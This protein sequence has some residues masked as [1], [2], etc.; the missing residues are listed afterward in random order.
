MTVASLAVTVP[1]REG[2]ETVD[3]TQWLNVTAFGRL[4][5]DLAQ[6]G[7]GEMV[8]VIGRAQLRRYQAQDGGAREEIGIVADSLVSARTSRPSS[9]KRTASSG[10][11]TS[12]LSLSPSSTM[13]SRFRDDRAW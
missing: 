7:K 8:A 12:S 5:D 2:G 13:I 4:A 11:S 10:S 6:H 1:L 3:A 9:G